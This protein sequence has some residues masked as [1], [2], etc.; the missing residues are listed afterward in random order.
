M[1]VGIIG[2]LAAVAIPAYQ[3]YQD[4]AAQNS[5]QISAK[6]IYKAATACLAS[7]IA[8]ATCLSTTIN[9]SIDTSCGSAILSVDGCQITGVDKTKYCVSVRVKDKGYCIDRSGG[10]KVSVAG[11]DDGTDAAKSVCL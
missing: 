5:A 8:H 4:N 10:K 9:G 3:S 7:G 6:S 11:C 1:V 2:V